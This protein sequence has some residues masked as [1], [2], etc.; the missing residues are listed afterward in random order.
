MSLEIHIIPALETNYIFCITEIKSKETIIVDPGESQ[1]VLDLIR[2]NN[3]NVI[4]IWNTHHHK[5][6]TG[7]NKIIQNTTQCKIFSPFNENKDTIN[8][9]N[10]ISVKHNDIITFNNLNIRIIATPGHTLDSICYFIEEKNILLA[11]DTLFHLGCGRLFEG[12][13]KLMLKSL[14][15]IKAL[16]LNTLIYCAHEYTLDNCKFAIYVDPNNKDLKS[17]YLQLLNKRQT[18][19][20]TIPFTLKKDLNFNPFL[21]THEIDFATKHNFLASKEED[22]FSYLRTK[23]DNFSINKTLL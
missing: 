19:S 16:P 1:P 21:R 13:A 6:H 4:A 12:S 22:F 14:N 3:L 2:K 5:D 9:K 10:H 7:G 17:Y 20:P 11:G 23:K 15:R 18:N 8:K